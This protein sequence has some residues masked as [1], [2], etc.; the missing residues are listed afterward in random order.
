MGAQI[1]NTTDCTGI[2]ITQAMFQ[3][4]QTLGKDYNVDVDGIIIDCSKIEKSHFYFGAKND[5]TIG[6][7]QDSKSFHRRVLLS[8]DGS[9]SYESWKDDDYDERGRRISL[10]LEGSGT[11]KQINPEFNAVLI[12]ALYGWEEVGESV[13]PTAAQKARA[14]SFRL[15]AGLDKK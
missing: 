11:P 15:A 9:V 1:K 2:Q 7:A 10:P 5:G 6:I 8:F 14:T 4:L 13:K 12:G 3:A